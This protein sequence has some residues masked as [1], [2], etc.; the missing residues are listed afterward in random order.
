MIFNVILFGLLIILTLYPLGFLI[1]SKYK[2]KLNNYEKVLFSFLYS[3]VVFVISSIVLGFL[4]LRFFLLP[5]VLVFSIYSLIKNHKKMY[6]A[7]FGMFKDVG[8]LLLFIVCLIFQGFI[9]FPSGY[10]YTQGYQFWSSQGHDGLWH[11]SLIEEVKKS[12]PLNNPTYSG[13]KLFNYHYFVDVLMGE[14]GRIFPFFSSLDLYF[15]YFTAVFSFLIVLSVFS[16]VLRWQKNKISGYWAIFFTILT[17]SFGYLVTYF[18]NGNLF[19]GETIFWAAQGNSI[20]GNPPHAISYSLITASFL[21]LYLYLK[22]RD[23]FWIFSTFLLSG[24][25]A[26][27]KVMAGAVFLVFFAAVIFSDFIFKKDKKVIFLFFSI[28]LSNFLVFKLLTKNGESLLLFEPWWFIRT[29]IV[30][31]DR[32]NLV[33]LELKRQHYLS[34][35][36]LKGFLRVIQIEL[37]GLFIYIIGNL[38]MRS[39]GILNLVRKFVLNLKDTFKNSIEVGLFAGALFSLVVTLLFVQK[40]IIYNLIAFMQYFLLIVGFFAASEYGLIMK[41]IKKVYLKFLLIVISISLSMPTVIGNL[42]DFYGNDGKKNALSLI[43]N[44]EIDAL[45]SLEE[46]SDEKSIILTLPFDKNSNK[47]YQNQPWPIHV[48]YPTSYVSAISSRQTFFTA[49][50]QNLITGYDTKTRFEYSNKFFTQEDVLWNE[51]F[52]KVNNISHIYITKAD[53]QELQKTR[54]LEVFFENEEVIIYKVI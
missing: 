25:L 31:P 8:F 39:V 15:R 13:E 54:Y 32:L 22:T 42:V 35:Q 53:K 40:G 21:S 43:T 38:G 12:M 5:L 7:F 23:N 44:Q 16:F 29:M 28:F 48:W 3:F 34:Q 10:K 41:K 51:N 17:G 18:R 45:N 20:V 52:L 50:E 36:S 30:V 47:R 26:G 9:N 27:F 19:S 33:D 6:F 24:F 2:N 4:N 46:N 14:F 1:V 11:V 37:G 49:E